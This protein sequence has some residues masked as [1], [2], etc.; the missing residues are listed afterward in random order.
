MS[1]RR[2]ERG[3]HTGTNKRFYHQKNGG[4][5]PHSH[6][7]VYLFLL[8]FRYYVLVLEDNYGDGAGVGHG[9]ETLQSG[10]C[11]GRRHTSAHNW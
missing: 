9:G 3:K 2:D 1:E 6:I 8:Q 4:V 11:P 10:V 5:Q 7:C